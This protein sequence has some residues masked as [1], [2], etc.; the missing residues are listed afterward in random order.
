MVGWYEKMLLNIIDCFLLQ[1]LKYSCYIAGNILFG[2]SLATVRSYMSNSSTP[3]YLLSGEKRRS[4]KIISIGIPFSSFNLAN[5]FR[6]QREGT[7]L[8]FLDRMAIYRTKT[9]LPGHCR[10][11]RHIERLA[12]PVLTYVGAVALPS[13]R[14]NCEITMNLNVG[15]NT[16]SSSK[17]DYHLTCHVLSCSCLYK[18]QSLN[19]MLHVWGP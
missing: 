6:W 15:L 13:N 12:I 14:I 17:G 1:N 9:I 4:Q 3:M 8:P 19:C 2:N 11:G 7:S 18:I 10:F 16:I 5:L